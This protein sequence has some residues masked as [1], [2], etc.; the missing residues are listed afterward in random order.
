MNEI[1]TF[2]T[3]YSLN[4]GIKVLVK[5]A[6]P[7]CD[8]LTVI[9]YEVDSG[10]VDFLKDQG[11]NLVDG[12]ALAEKYKINS[13]ISSYTL[14]TIFFY[15][16]SKYHTDSDQTYLCDFTDLWVRNS[17]FSL[18]TNDKAYVTSENHLIG[19]CETNTTWINICYNRDIFNILRNKEI[20]N[21]GS[22]LGKRAACVE[23]LNEM[24]LEVAYVMQR[25]GNYPIIDQAIMNKVVYFDL[26]RYNI[27]RHKEIV[28]LA[29]SADM[30]NF[31]RSCVV[32]QYDVN[33][34]L[35]AMLYEQYK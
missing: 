2:G 32:H 5:S 1:I 6:K 26:F 14:K 4:D 28:N 27:L 34:Q 16:Y 23:L 15:L 10:L 25:S 24:V 3:K 9:V 33:K 11:V 21:G 29:Y 8:K 19:E 17:P 13:Q 12:K 31:T 35:E 18:I 30:A 22:I 20:L 7:N